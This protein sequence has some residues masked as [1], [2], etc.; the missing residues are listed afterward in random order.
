MSLQKTFHRRVTSHDARIAERRSS[1]K[2][3]PCTYRA[4]CRVHCR[5]HGSSA[6]Q[7]TAERPSQITGTFALQPELYIIAAITVVS[8]AR[9]IFAQTSPRVMTEHGSLH[10]STPRSYIRPIMRNKRAL[11]RIPSWLSA[12][13]VTVCGRTKRLRISSSPSFFAK[14]RAFILTESSGFPGPSHPTR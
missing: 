4:V 14:P 13:S 12:R 5:F 11:S 1:R 2:S 8:N 6:T 9:R 3:P 7:R 10:G